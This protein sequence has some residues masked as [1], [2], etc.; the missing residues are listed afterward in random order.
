MQ[1]VLQEARQNFLQL[2]STE[3][4]AVVQ[5]DLW[6]QAMVEDRGDFSI[7]NDSANV[8][9]RYASNGINDVHVKKIILLYGT[10]DHVRNGITETNTWTPCDGPAH[11]DRVKESAAGTFFDSV[12]IPLSAFHSD[13]CIYIGAWVTLVNTAGFQWCTFPIP[14]DENIQGI[15]TWKS[16]LKYCK[17]DCGGGGD[18]S[19]VCGNLRTVTP[20][21]WGSK[22]HGNNPGKYLHDNFAAAFPNGVTIGCA[23][24]NFWVKFTSAQAITDYLPAGGE[25]KKLKKNYTNP[26]TRDLKNSLAQHVLALTLNVQFDLFDPNFGEGGVHLEDMIINSGKF[27]GWTVGAFL[28]LAN[29]VLGGCNTQYKAKDVVSTAEKIN[30]FFK[31]GRRPGHHGHDDNDDDDH[32]DDHDDDDH[33]EGCKPDFLKCPTER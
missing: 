4:G 10:R 20:G 12:L 8:I 11:P 13:S 27:K 24:D 32:D 18:D 21:G 2:D 9:I 3:C 1:A 29:K 7:S 22:P 17:Q 23:P 30:E 15:S 33:H 19:V 25:P 5:K 14:F 28:D 31:N 16:Y 6:D 26:K